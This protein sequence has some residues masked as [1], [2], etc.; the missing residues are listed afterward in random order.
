MQAQTILNLPSNYAEEKFKFSP[1]EHSARYKIQK[2]AHNQGKF[3]TRIVS[4][5]SDNWTKQFKLCCELNRNKIVNEKLLPSWHLK[6]EEST[7]MTQKEGSTKEEK[8]SGYL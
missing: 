2:N 7:K 5:V 1:V 6:Y 4:L 3:C 8:V